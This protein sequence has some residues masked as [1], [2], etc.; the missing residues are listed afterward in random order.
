MRKRFLSIAAVCCVSLLFFWLSLQIIRARHQ[1]KI[2]NVAS[3]LRYLSLALSNY[4]IVNEKLP[5][6]NVAV[7][8]PS[9]REHWMVAVLPFMEHNELYASLDLENRW[10]TPH[11]LKAVESQRSFREFA[12]GLDYV[13]CPY[14][15]DKSIWDQSTGEPIGRIENHPDAILLVAIPYQNSMP[16]QISYVTAAQVLEIVRKNQEAFFIRCN[17]K[18]GRITEVDGSITFVNR[19][20]LSKQVDEPHDQPNH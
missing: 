9:L 2:M 3:Q 1:A 18:N 10:S 15:A 16:F 17:N 20:S 5:S 6:I 12:T 13:I 7:E 4:E 11:N 8:E 19:D 14:V